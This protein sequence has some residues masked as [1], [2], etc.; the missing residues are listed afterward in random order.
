M[1]R[2]PKPTALKALA[3]NP[4][5]RKAGAAPAPL[6]VPP[7]MAAGEFAPPAD[8]TERECKVWVTELA[9]WQGAG[10]AR[11]SDLMAF[12]AYVEARAL[13]LRCKEVVD[14]KGPTYTTRSKHGSMVR[15]RPE[16]KIM[17]AQSRLMTKLS[18]QLAANTKQRIATTSQLATAKQYDLFPVAQQ[19]EGAGAAKPVQNDD[20]VGWLQ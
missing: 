17:N 10:L 3:G 13:Y 8:L 9:R 15:E 1:S 11:P 7:D 19:A 2:P 5:R 16:V 14:K 4:G 20:P 6:P 18:D 12:R